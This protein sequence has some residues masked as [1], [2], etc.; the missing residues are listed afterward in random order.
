MKNSIN[1]ADKRFQAYLHNFQIRMN[2]EEFSAVKEVIKLHRLMEAADILQDAEDYQVYEKCLEYIDK[3]LS[4]T[5][6][7]KYSFSLN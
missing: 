2:S 1:K 4:D 3:F 6:Q 7:S 5:T